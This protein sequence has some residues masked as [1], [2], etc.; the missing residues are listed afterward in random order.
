MNVLPAEIQSS[1]ALACMKFVANEAG[2]IQCKH[3]E[4]DQMV[5]QVSLMTAFKGFSL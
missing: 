3:S 2:Y 5:L 4:E 1:L